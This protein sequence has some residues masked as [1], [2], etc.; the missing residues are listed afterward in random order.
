[1]NV[2]LKLGLSLAIL[3]VA[4]RNVDFAELAMQFRRLD[5]ASLLLALALITLSTVLAA[6]RWRV[7]S[8]A[9]LGA[10]PKLP[11]FLRSFYRGA[12]LNQGLP[13][14]LGG[15]ALRVLDLGRS[16]GKR[17][18]FGTVLFDRVIGLSGLLIINVLMLPVSL[19]VLPMPL[20]IAVGGISVAGL[21]AIGIGIALP[22][23]RI[24]HHHRALDLIAEL[25]SFGR[26]VLAHPRGFLLQCALSVS[27]HLCAVL[28]MFVLARQFGIEASLLTHLAIQ[29]SV[30]IVV[31]L[32]VSLAGWGV[33]EGSMAALFALI[34]VAAPAVM[35]TSLTFGLLVLIST[36]PGLVFMIG[37]SAS[38]EPN[39]RSAAGTAT[40]DGKQ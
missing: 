29:P 4:F 27:V 21:L 10:I 3:L 1:M 20:A 30:F 19:S 35:A 8:G 16:I 6:T 39:Q 31:T 34:G 22:W 5:A 33:R 2:L 18:A 38:A 26:R 11:F 7:I 13:T 12:F 28:A 40:A 17:E 36:L 15:D 32:P 14:T 23:Q 37:R 24:S 25:S 9:A